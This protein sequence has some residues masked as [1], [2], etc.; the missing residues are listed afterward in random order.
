MKNWG[1]LLF[2]NTLPENLNVGKSHLPMMILSYID[3]ILVALH[4]QE[5]RG[6]RGICW[7][8]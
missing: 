2:S 6:Q 7:L 8:G 4:M 3:N 5:D 1:K